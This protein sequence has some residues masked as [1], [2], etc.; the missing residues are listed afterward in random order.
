MD[1]VKII[2]NTIGTDYNSPTGD[3]IPANGQKLIDPSRYSIWADAIFDAEADYVALRTKFDSG[4]LVVNDGLDDLLAFYGKKYLSYINE[5]FSGRFQAEP[6]R[7]NGFILNDNN[8][9]EA[10]EFSKGAAFEN[11]TDTLQF[12]RQGQSSNGTFLLTINNVVGKDSQDV[13]PHNV[14]FNK[15]SVSASSNP[16]K[17]TVSLWK[18]NADQTTRTVIYSENFGGSELNW[19]VHSGFTLV[20]Q[21]IVVAAGYGVYVQVSAVGNPKPSDINVLLWTRKQ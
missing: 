20:N 1:F 17:F 7:T 12:G 5:A 8:M 16:A 3:L 15:F 13:F 11:D 18:V 21:G 2:K 6:E 14:I 4:D 9:Q 19:D 10:I